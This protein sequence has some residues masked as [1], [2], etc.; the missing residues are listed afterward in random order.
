[1][2][3]LGVP[4]PLLSLVRDDPSKGR[5]EGGGSLMPTGF[6]LITRDTSLS[7]Y[8]LPVFLEY[9]SFLLFFYVFSI[10]SR[11]PF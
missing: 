3:P 10:F 8:C 6:R 5:L 1:M 2:E 11:L 9:S 4:G 7:L